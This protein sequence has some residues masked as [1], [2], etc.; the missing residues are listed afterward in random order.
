MGKGQNF[1]VVAAMTLIGAAGGFCI[2]LMFVFLGPYVLYS[3]QNPAAQ[4][5][6]D[7]IQIGSKVE[8]ALAV[9]NNDTSPYDVG[10]DSDTI[11]ISRGGMTCSVRLQNGQVAATHISKD[12]EVRE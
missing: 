3:I 2:T 7:Q 11:F 4:T 1:F 9:I 6:C 10:Y 5:E 8:D 12:P